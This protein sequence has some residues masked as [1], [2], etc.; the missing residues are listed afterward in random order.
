MHRSDT[1]NDDVS[2][3]SQNTRMRSAN[4]NT[5]QSLLSTGKWQINNIVQARQWL[6]KYGYTL[7]SDVIPTKQTSYILLS[8]AQSQTGKALQEGIHAIAHLLDDQLDK[9]EA[10]LIRQEIVNLVSDKLSPLISRVEATV[11]SLSLQTD[12]IRA[13]NEANPHPLAPF[14]PHIPP[15]PRP[16]SHATAVATQLPIAHSSNLAHACTRNH[17]LLIDKDP[18]IGLDSLSE[19]NENELV[20]KAN[21]AVEKASNDGANYTGVEFGSA[22]RLQNGTPHPSLKNGSSQLY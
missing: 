9:T 22:K 8:I 1:S 16:G 7:A 5:T 19:L 3:P 13:T 21:A 17:Q 12:A 14:P 11:T 2:P 4:N 10:G 20:Q 18:S 15:S 6:E